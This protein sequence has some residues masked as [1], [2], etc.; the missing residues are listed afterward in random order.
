MLELVQIILKVIRHGNV[1]IPSRVIP[2][3]VETT[4]LGAG[5]IHGD[6]VLFL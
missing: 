5:P 6:S 3:D 2:L 4:E 1:A